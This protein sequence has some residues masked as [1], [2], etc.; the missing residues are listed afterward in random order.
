MV[1]GAGEK[2]GQA[3]RDDGLFFCNHL[4]H[5]TIDWLNP[6]NQ[7]SSMVFLLRFTSQHETSKGSSEPKLMALRTVV[8]CQP[9]PEGGIVLVRL[10]V[11]V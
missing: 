3:V 6:F 2:Q 9:S 4:K 10:L 5:Q 7:A 11:L 8:P 1:T